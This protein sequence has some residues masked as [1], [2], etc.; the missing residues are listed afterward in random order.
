MGGLTL[1]NLLFSSSSFPRFT[2]LL[3]CRAREKKASLTYITQ[4][5]SGTR[6]EKWPSRPPI[7]PGHAHGSYKRRCVLYISSI[8]KFTRPCISIFSRPLLKTAQFKSFWPEEAAAAAE[9]YK[10]GGKRKKI[11][12]SQPSMHCVCPE[13]GFSVTFLLLLLSPFLFSLFPSSR[14]FFF[15]KQ[16]RQ[17]DSA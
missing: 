14:F 5:K 10:R 7:Y 13:I 3:A 8:Y 2:K 1:H 15:P 16:N 4:P 12:P 9:Y 17:A 11:D 6:H